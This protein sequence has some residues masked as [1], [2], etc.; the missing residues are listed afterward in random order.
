M[1]QIIAVFLVCL[2]QSATAMNR[3]DVFSNNIS[4]DLVL[5]ISDDGFLLEYTDSG[6]E[7]IGES[8]PG[9]S[10]FSLQLKANERNERE[11]LIF[12]ID[13]S[14]QLFQTNG[15]TWVELL[16]PPE[17]HSA[18]TLSSVISLSPASIQLVL[19]SEEGDL[20]IN[21]SDTSWVSP[22]ETFP[23]S[24]PRD[25]TFYSDEATYTINPF[26]IG[27]DGKLYGFYNGGWQTAELPESEWNIQNLE[28]Y[29]H[30][31][32][33]T[34]FLIAV[35]GLGQLYDNVNQGILASSIHDPCPGTGPWDFKL[36]NS[37]P[38]I[39]DLLCLDSTG[40]LFLAYDGSWSRLA[41]S[42]PQE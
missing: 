12:V 38:G 13:S 36:V 8:C 4:G 14:G 27:A 5:A 40:Q 23:S 2:I 7:T 18:I 20:F 21:D 17:T 30:S 22:F 26:I 33:G 28:S 10:P 29:V 39:F 41:D 19:I 6:W 32:T 3:F 15:D 16:S 42:F 24:P 1:K 25:M 31:E 37:G 35:D 34:I 11:A 9:T